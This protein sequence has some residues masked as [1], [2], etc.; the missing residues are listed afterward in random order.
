[1]R[2][3]CLELVASEFGHIE[4]F[5]LVAVQD[6]VDVKNRLGGVIVFKLALVCVGDHDQRQME[7]RTMINHGVHRANKRRHFSLDRYARFLFYRLH[8][9]DQHSFI[10]R[11]GQHRQIGY[12]RCEFFG[13]NRR[14]E[15]RNEH[16]E[17]GHDGFADHIQ[18]IMR[19]VLPAQPQKTR[20]PNNKK[21]KDRSHDSIMRAVLLDRT[22]RGRQQQIRFAAMPALGQHELDVED[23]V[24]RTVNILGTHILDK[25]IDGD[26]GENE[27]V[28]ATGIDLFQAAIKTDRW[29][30]GKW[31]VLNVRPIRLELV[32]P[33]FR[34]V[35]RLILVGVNDEIDGVY[36]LG[37]EIEVKLGRIAF[38]V[39]DERK[40]KIST[41]IDHI[42]HRT[43]EWNDFALYRHTGLFLYGSYKID[44]HTLVSAFRDDW[45]LSDAADQL[46]GYGRRREEAQGKQ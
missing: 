1:M 20:Q 46:F 9:I 40:M 16:A 14:G 39:D 21:Q 31:K 7:V 25:R 3:I 38:R 17:T 35:E 13:H 6:E 44:E 19:F 41:V 10:R 32:C 36:R 15:Q 30:D 12:T 34:H 4:W 26:I 23:L 33:Q 28:Y 45:H 11:V 43:R 8:E 2:P 18:L 27:P 37:G 5:V 42:V 29:L 24:Q 22:D